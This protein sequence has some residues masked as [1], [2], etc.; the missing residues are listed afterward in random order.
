MVKLPREAM[1]GLRQKRPRLNLSA[2][3]C[4]LLHRRV[5]E[6]DGWRCQNCGSS[7]NLHKHH[8][9][10]RS[11]LGD[12]GLDNLIRLCANCHHNHQ[13]RIIGGN[14]AL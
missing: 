7:E 9:T 2:G 12:D 11:R 10:K 1:Q 4:K 6:R 8:L 3:D 13:F 14:A 5:L